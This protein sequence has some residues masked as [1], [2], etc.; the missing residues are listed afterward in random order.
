MLLEVLMQ[1]SCIISEKLSPLERRVC[2]IQIVIITNFVVVSS[3]GVKR[4]D[5]NWEE[6]NRFSNQSEWLG[7]A[8]AYRSGCCSIPSQAIPKAF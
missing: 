7:R 5:C 1:Y 4:D 8:S 6:R 3:V 2:D